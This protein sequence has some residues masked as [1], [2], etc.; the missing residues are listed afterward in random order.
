MTDN[1]H[2]SLHLNESILLCFITTT[3][4]IIII[5]IKIQIIKAKDIT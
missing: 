4:I 2:T 1:V 5:I 3:T